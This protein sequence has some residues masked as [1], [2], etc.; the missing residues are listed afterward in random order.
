MRMVVE[1]VKLRGGA[2]LEQV[3]DALRLWGEVGHLTAQG[4]AGLGREG[5]GVEQGGERGGT[6]TRGAAAKELPAVDVELLFQ[7]WVHRSNPW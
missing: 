1:E 6:D 7:T 5:V 4:L 2:R 3:D